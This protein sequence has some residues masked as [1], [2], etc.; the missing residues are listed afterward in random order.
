MRLIPVQ[1]P[2]LPVDFHF[3]IIWMVEDL[4]DRLKKIRFI[5]W[6]I[7]IY[8]NSCIM[9]DFEKNPALLIVTKMSVEREGSPTFSIEIQ[10][11]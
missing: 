5:G 11:S 1:I 9:I 7:E 6:G 2:Y 10:K 4:K 8:Y 3:M